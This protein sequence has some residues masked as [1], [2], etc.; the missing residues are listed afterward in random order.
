MRH[1][2]DD[3]LVMTCYPRIPSTGFKLSMGR[4]ICGNLSC[5]FS[6]CVPVGWVAQCCAC[7]SRTDPSRVRE[8]TRTGCTFVSWRYYQGVVRIGSPQWPSPTWKYLCTQR[9]KISCGDLQV[10]RKSCPP[11]ARKNIDFSKQCMCVSCCFPVLLSTL[12]VLDYGEYVAWER[13]RAL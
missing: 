12:R 11:A 3:D 8:T 4:S 6:Q 7:Q 1:N 9:H 5:R 2:H 13:Q 10:M